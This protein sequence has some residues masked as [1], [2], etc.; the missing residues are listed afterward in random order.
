M[1]L[2]TGSLII[3]GIVSLS[4]VWSVTTPVG[5]VINMPDPLCCDDCSCQD[6][7]VCARCD[8]CVW[9]SQCSEGARIQDGARFK[10]MASPR[11]AAGDS[12]NVIV[13]LDPPY[14]ADDSAIL[15]FDMPPGFYMDDPSDMRVILDPSRRSTISKTI[16]VKDLV[17]EQDHII[18]ARLYDD[19]FQ[20]LSMAQLEISVYWEEPIIP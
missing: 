6:Q 20:D 2:Y 5:A 12:F 10:L 9:T 18:R 15:A 4:I 16:H 13:V 1:V 3:L 8:S 19:S 11:V 7:G 14:Y 17:A